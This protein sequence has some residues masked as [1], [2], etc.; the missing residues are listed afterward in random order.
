MNRNALALLAALSCAA[1]S[2]LFLAPARNRIVSPVHAAEAAPAAVTVD[3]PRLGSIFPP[4]ITPPTFLWRDRLESPGRWR[5]DITFG[6]GSAPLHFESPG[7]K[8]SVGE[9]DPRCV[10][11]TNE[12]PQRAYL[13]SGCRLLGDHQE[14]FR[15][16][17]RHRG[18]LRFSPR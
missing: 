8:M 9:I 7:E 13:A 3:Y 1:A 16:R 11:S 5:I 18:H 17:P 2:F 6:D 14:A 12:L 4:E 15:R 10:S